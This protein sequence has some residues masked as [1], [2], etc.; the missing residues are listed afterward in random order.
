M[1]D[2]LA[3]W[4][5]LREPAD[6]TARSE[7][8]TRVV[9]DAIG[10]HDP[11]YALD[12]ATG[13]GS[14][15]RYLMNRL[16]G[17]RQHWLAIDRSSMLLA[18][19]P[20]RMSQWGAARG[21]EVARN[22]AGCVMRSER[23]ECQIETRQLDLGALD[24]A[25]VF[26]QHHL[27]TASA[28]LDL[29]SEEWLLSLAALCRATGAAALFTITY[30][31]RSSCLPTEPEDAL[32]LELFNR[33]Q[34]TDKGL[35]G[36]AAGPAATGCAVRAFAAAGY[37]VQSEPSDWTLGSGEAQLQRQLIDG[38]AEAAAELEP[39]AAS[40]I[41]SWRMRRLRHVDAGRSRVVVGHDDVAAW[42]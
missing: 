21:F 4:L 37:H 34:R 15:I 42:L 2:A 40:T 33:H 31:G 13:A 23:L 14:N 7:S 41:A 5:A 29:V 10:A 22:A 19:L 11:V 8:L 16:P 18:Q 20:I 17:R 30:N 39:D 6:T 1:D 3:E 24:A 38:W 12:L 26:T 25:Q 9:A 28:L 27:V 36:V 35:G 32:I